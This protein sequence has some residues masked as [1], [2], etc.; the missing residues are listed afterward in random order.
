MSDPRHQRGAR[1]EQV[2]VE[3]LQASGYKILERNF[4]CRA[5]EIDI[6]AEDSDDV[7]CFIEVRTRRQGA[8]V[9]GASSVTFRKRQRIVRASRFYCQRHHI[10]NRAMRFDVVSLAA[11]AQGEYV[12]EVIRNAFDAQAQL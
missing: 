5:G 10:S 11:D 6:I 4:S 2:A 3:N 9:S 12:L 8:M 7:L 1:G